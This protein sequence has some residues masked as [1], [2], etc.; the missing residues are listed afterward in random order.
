MSRQTLKTVLIGAF[1]SILLASTVSSEPTKA[2][3]ESFD[4][5]WNTI[6]ERFYDAEFNGVDWSESRERYRPRIAEVD[7]DDAFY[8]IINTMLFELSVS[9]LGVVPVDDPK[10]LGEA[11]VFGEG[12]TGIEARLVDD[13]LFIVGVESGSTAAAAGLRPGF[14][15]LSLNGRRLKDI[16]DEA[17]RFPT[18]PFTKR[19]E[20]YNVLG[21]V[22]WELLGP[23]AEK[24]AVEVKDRNGHVFRHTLERQSRG[25]QQVFDEGMPPTYV[26]LESRRIDDEIGY[27]RFNSFHPAL[28]EDLL[29]SVDELGNTKGLIIDLR[30]NPGG[31]FGV[32]A[33]LASRFITER[34]IIWRYRGRNGIDDIY[35]DPVEQPYMGALVILVD[36]ASASSSEEFSG[37]LQGLQRA[38]IVGQRTPGRDVVMDLTVLPIGAYFV[39]PVA[40]TMTCQDVVLEHRG[41]IPDVES[42]FTLEAMK[43]G[44]DVQLD[45]ALAVINASDNR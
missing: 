3:I 40:E 5:V 21:E 45:A 35:I 37:G 32:R 10:Q 42:L 23:A 44:R 7:N 20:R 4:I 26:S 11:A 1:C 27:I 24:V 31:A 19:N 15:I 22:Y 18:P 41:V 28:L 25:A 6:N 16:T 8:E 43:T 12:T 33:Q 14:E 13:R 38:T 36:G 9:H 2:Y 30:G 29:T 34:S 17:L 39:F